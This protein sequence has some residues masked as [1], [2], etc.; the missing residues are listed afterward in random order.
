MPRRRANS[1]SGGREREW[2]EW[3]WT[4]P[5]NRQ[6]DGADIPLG[7]AAADAY[8]DI[9]PSAAVGAEQERNTRENVRHRLRQRRME[10]RSRTDM[11]QNPQANSEVDPGVAEVLPAPG[12]PASAPMVGMTVGSSPAL[13]RTGLSDDQTAAMYNYYVPSRYSTQGMRNQMASRGFFTTP[14][15]AKIYSSTGEESAKEEEELK[16][17]GINGGTGLY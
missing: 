2:D 4:L 9:P 11:A 6:Y 17:G 5:Q 10:R 3:Y 16:R 14:S 8:A 1:F 12:D 7:Y 13:H 15:G